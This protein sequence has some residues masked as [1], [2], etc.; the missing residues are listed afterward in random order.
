MCNH[1]LRNSERPL[2]AAATLVAN[3]AEYA[4]RLVLPRGSD[5]IRQAEAAADLA[6]VDFV[7]AQTAAQS[8]VHFI[9]RHQDRR[10]TRQEPRATLNDIR[11]LVGIL[12]RR[13]HWVGVTLRINSDGCARV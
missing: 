7:V 11:G 5:P 13:A 8:T 4:A 1:H 6:G 2:V 10:V 12:R 3:H 9:A